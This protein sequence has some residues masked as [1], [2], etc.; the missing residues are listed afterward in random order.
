M[1]TDFLARLCGLVYLLLILTGIYGLV[2]VPAVLF[3]WTDPAATARNILENEMTFRLAVTAEIACYL[4]FIVLPL[5]LYKLLRSVH[6]DVAV[7]MVVLA[8]LS[9]PI[10]LTQVVKHVDVLLL[11][12]EQE[13][14]KAMTTETV[15][16]IIMLR[17]ASFNNG[18]LL[19]YL[20]AGLWLLPLGYLVHTSGFLP[21]VLGVLLMLACLGYLIEFVGKFIFSW[22]QIPWY[23]S[24]PSSLGEFGTCLWLLIFG[25]RPTVFR[26]KATIARN[27]LL[28]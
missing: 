17:L 4:C 8:L 1:S 11:L 19:S 10:T 15:Q 26:K 27:A 22:P 7:L 18:I 12:N 24:V 14:L 25:A 3:D 20:F 9:I 2:Y 23:V 13:Y 6:Q 21:R 28:S 16:A 5:L